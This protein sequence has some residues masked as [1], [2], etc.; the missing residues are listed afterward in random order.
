MPDRSPGDPPPR[1]PPLPEDEWDE[2]LKAVVAAT[3]PL[4]IFTTLARHPDLFQ[5]WIGL[6]SR[7]LYGGTLPPRV[8][9]L[10][11]LRTAH[12]RSCAYEQVHHHRIGLEAGLTEDEID[13]LR[14]DPDDHDWGDEDRAVL[15]AADELHSDGTLSDTVWDALA[16]RFDE[17]GLIELVMLVGH[18]HMVAFALNTLRIRPEE[19]H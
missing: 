9:E 10:A 4:N 3:G 11:I 13:A 16:A 7:L 1:I 17:R 8:R 5:S 12:H 6:G 18:Y 19:E 15:A 2:T 14:K